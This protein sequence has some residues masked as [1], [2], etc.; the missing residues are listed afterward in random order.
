MKP[1]A[2]RRAIYEP[3]ADINVTPFVD[4]MLVL[5][6]VFMI[7]A[8]ML[9]SGMRVDLPQAKSAQPLNPKEPVIITVRKDGKLFLGQE[10]LLPGQVGDAVRAKLSDDR[11]RAIH[12]RGDRDVVYGDIVAIVDQLAA[13]G[14]LKVALLANARSND[15][16]PASRPPA[17]EDHSGR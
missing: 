2:Q 1:I 9:A 7:T 14:F 10:E 13:N 5:L 17:G 11:E 12:L 8:P 3:L 6:I 16:P 4:V 15:R